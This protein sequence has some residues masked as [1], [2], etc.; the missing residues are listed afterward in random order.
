MDQALDKLL[1]TQVQAQEYE[2]VKCL[3][4]SQVLQKCLKHYL[5]VLYCWMQLTC[6]IQAI[7]NSVYFWIET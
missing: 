5:Q 3:I 2:D 1:C 6:H 7:V 4:D